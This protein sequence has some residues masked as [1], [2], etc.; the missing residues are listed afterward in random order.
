ML[1][2]INSS[3]FIAYNSNLIFKN[4]E[5]MES[6]SLIICLHK[7]M[8][9]RLIFIMLITQLCIGNINHESMSL[10][11]TENKKE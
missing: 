9:I 10:P 3:G 6:I 8:V 11:P 5:R 1:I 7:F 2:H 4:I